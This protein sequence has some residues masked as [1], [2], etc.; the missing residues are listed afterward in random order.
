L[1][2]EA[3]TDY[4]NA[5][6]IISRA[7]RPTIRVFPSSR[8]GQLGCLSLQQSL[9]ECGGPN[10]IARRTEEPKINKFKWM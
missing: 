10:C 1:F 4:A 3:S 6:V 9:P 8:A 7:E 5:R 2:V